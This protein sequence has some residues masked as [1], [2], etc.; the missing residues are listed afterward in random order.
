[1][2]DTETTVPIEVS[3]LDVTSPSQVDKTGHWISK[4]EN[5]KNY[6]YTCVKGKCTCCM[7]Q[8]VYMTI[9]LKHIL[10]YFIGFKFIIANG[11]FFL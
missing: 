3:G 7:Q 1:M 6:Y 4:H 10:E 11:W 8:F 9:S 2:H 5:K